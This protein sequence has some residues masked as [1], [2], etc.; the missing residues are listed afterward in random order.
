MI[1]ITVCFFT[2]AI[3]ITVMNK[4]VHPI[5]VSK[6]KYI[7]LAKEIQ[8]IVADEQTAQNAN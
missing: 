6:Q 3:I 5:P 1:K 7:K 2:A 4:K 8:K